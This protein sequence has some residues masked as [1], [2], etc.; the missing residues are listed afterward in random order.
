MA[1]KALELQ[2]VTKR[3]GR[4]NV[5]SEVSFDVHEGEIFGFVGPNGAGKST[6][7]R[8]ILGLC[9]PTSGRIRVFG[10]DIVTEFE[11][12]IRYV[13]SASEVPCFYKERTGRENLAYAAH[14]GG[15][16]ATAAIEQAARRVGLADQV[17][18]KVKKYSLGMRQRLSL[19][20]AI[21]GSP[22]LLILDEPTNGLDPGGIRDLRRLIRSF[23]R[24]DGMACFLS[25][26]LLGEVEQLCDRFAMIDHG[27]LVATGELGAGE[28]AL[29]V[30]LL[31]DDARRAE[32]VLSARGHF[33]FSV[34]GNELV[35]EVDREAIPEINVVLVEAGIRVFGISRANTLES[36]YLTRTEGHAV[37]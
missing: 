21:V 29:P 28:S 3:Y 4:R 11:S 20:V 8:M 2:G 35:G 12:A 33:G 1:E 27:K 24:D 5:V 25:S 14:L 17:D 7:M 22:K 31:V 13:G 34:C 26:H 32:S 19:A 15:V 6:T 36:F 18:E 30:H 23:A 9:R 37:V 10:R 16:K